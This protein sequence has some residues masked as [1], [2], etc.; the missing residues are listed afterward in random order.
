MSMCKRFR[1]A[2]NYPTFSVEVED[3]PIVPW[4][5]SHYVQALV[6]TPCQNKLLEP[7][8][9]EIRLKGTIRRPRRAAVLSILSTEGK[10]TYG[11]QT[12]YTR[13]LQDFL[14]TVSLE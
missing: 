5:L 4:V 14:C 2:L 9:E 13:F 7:S 6:S 12:E 8:L 10:S 1:W 3:L 11:K